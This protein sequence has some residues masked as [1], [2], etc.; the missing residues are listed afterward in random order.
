MT[1]QDTR[2]FVDFVRYMY[3]ENCSERLK[4][5]NEPYPTAKA[6]L[7]KNRR[8]L[9]SLYQQKKKLIEKQT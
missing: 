5:G 6:Y 8:F 9:E 2:S 1:E 7:R 4:W 3:S